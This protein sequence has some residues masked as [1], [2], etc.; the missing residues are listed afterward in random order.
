M[1]TI[2]TGEVELVADKLW[3]L[4]ESR[5]PPF[6]ME[7]TVDVNEDAR[8]KYRYVDLRRPRMQRNIILR[9]KISFAVREVL[10]AQGFLEI[11]TP[12]MTRSTPEGARDYLV[13]SRVQP[14]H[15]LCAAAIAADLQA[16]ADGRAASTSISRSCAA[17]ATRICAPTASPSSRR[18]ISRCPSRRR[19]RS[20]KS[21][22]PLVQ[23]RV[24]SGGLQ[25]HGSVPAHELR[26]GDAQLRQRQARPPHSAVPLRGGSASGALTRG[27]LAAGGDPHSEDRRAEPQGAR[28]VE[29]VRTASAACASSTT[30]KRWTRLSRADGAVRERVGRGRRRSADAGR[31]GPASRRASVP[32]RP[33][34]QACGQLRLH[35][36]QKYN[37]QHKLLDPEEFRIPLGDRFPDVRM[38]RGRQ[39]LERR[40]SSVHVGARRGHR[41]ADQRSRRAAAPSPTTWC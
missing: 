18:S 38:G 15:V 3:I 32:K 23:A 39:A 35:V 9:S 8:L 14:G 25:S 13:P 11:E 19:S 34:T 12:F 28:R 41:E 27:R 26:R 36:A 31:A 21:I 5:T 10:Y 6:P 16:A 37:D 17:S 24:R 22:E 1:P 40:A 20:S 30:P 33:F 2:A 29:G 4:N 7:D